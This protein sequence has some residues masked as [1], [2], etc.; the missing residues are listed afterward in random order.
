MMLHGS[1][2]G[3]TWGKETRESVCDLSL[4]GLAIELCLRGDVL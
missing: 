1:G 4:C 3:V 2:C